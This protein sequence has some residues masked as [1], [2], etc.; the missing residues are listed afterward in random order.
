MKNPRS[1]EKTRGS[2]IKTPGSVVST[3]FKRGGFYSAVTDCACRV[4]LG[5]DL[6]WKIS[7]GALL[8][9]ASYGQRAEAG[10]A[11]GR[12]HFLRDPGAGAFVGGVSDRPAVPHGNSRG[13]HPRDAHVSDLPP[14]T[15]SP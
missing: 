7:P 5:A 6:A 15:D 10:M 4:P 11:S 8:D 14:C 13:G 12:D 1:S 9:S 3:I 2:M